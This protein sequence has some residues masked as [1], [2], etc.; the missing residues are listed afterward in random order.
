LIVLDLECEQGHGFEGW[1]ASTTAFEH[2]LAQDLISCP[3]CGAVHVVRRPSAPYVRTRSDSALAGEKQ[4]PSANRVSIEGL[5][6][7]LVAHLRSTARGLEDV[8]ERFADE[9]RRIHYGDAES[10]GIRGKANGQELRELLEEGISVL[11][12]PP[13]DSL[14]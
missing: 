3:N 9:A 8:G 6:E 1:F 13:D 11:P 14:H 12:I 10:R 2:Q 7:H 5:A 4:M